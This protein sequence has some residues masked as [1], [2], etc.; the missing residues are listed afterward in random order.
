MPL[1][2]QIKLTLV[3]VVLFLVLQAVQFTAFFST[4]AENVEGQVLDQ[5]ETSSRIF[6]RIFNERADQ[7]AVSVELL[8]NDFGFKDAVAE[9]EEATLRSALENL[10]NRI[11][12]ELAGVFDP[13]GELITFIGPDGLNHA[14]AVQQF[15][16]DRLD[17]EEVS[18]SAVV[19][20][21]QVFELVAAPIDSP[22]TIGWIVMGTALNETAAREIKSLSSID[23]QIAFL[24]QDG[25]TETWKVAASSGE[26]Q[27]LADFLKDQQ[28]NEL[29]SPGRLMLGS[30]PFASW[31]VPIAS[32][33]ASTKLSALLY[34]SLDIAYKPYQELGFAVGAVGILSLLALVIGAYFVS[35]GIS[36][37]LAKLAEAAQSLA[38]GESDSLAQ[39]PPQEGSKE[40][41]ALTN[42]FRH[43][44]GAVRDRERRIMH[45][46]MHDTE[47]GLPNRLSFEQ[48]VTNGV[49]LGTPFFVFIVTV[50]NLSQLRATL[51]LEQTTRLL[52]NTARRLSGHADASLAAMSFGTFAFVLTG[53]QS[54]QDKAES[55]QADFSK[56]VS[57]DG[58]AVDINV[59]IGVSR[60]PDHG[61]DVQTLLRH[62]HA[63]TDM[64]RK[65]A[66]R[67]AYYDPENDLN[68][69][70]SLTLMSDLRYGIESGEV[71]FAYQPKLC[72]KTGKVTSVE[73]L[74]R[75]ISKARGFVAPDDFIPLAERTGEIRTLTRWGLD[76]VICQVAEWRDQGLELQV[77]IN[78][79]SS[80]LINLDLP[81]LIDEGFKTYNVGPDSLYL[82]VTESAVMADM[83]RALATLRELSEMGIHLAIDDYGTGYSSLSYLKSL[84]VD[85]LKIDKSFILKL[86]EEE[87][88]NIL[89]KSTIELGHTL[90]LKVTA[91]GVED[92]VSVNRLKAYGCDHI[93]GYHI[94]RPMPAE[95]IPAA[96]STIEAAGHI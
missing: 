33:V 37:P 46:A 23:L 79:S 71:R 47:T 44:V 36:K 18:V 28:S 24:F 96:I 58:V 72:L 91:E 11:N 49:R 67:C 2:F 95:D 70:A 16:V 85:E 55:I 41:A 53:D 56:P 15:V 30:E 64:A 29:G 48:L 3:F 13:D 87:Q 51:S 77:G 63:A 5:L 22:R 78:L 12:V 4:T 25:A 60:Y 9:R 81:T 76:A 6:T 92:E 90:G 19:I 84:P 8:S 54:G 80:D 39:L 57:V 74:V 94:A 42:G 32:A 50:E 34:Y 7:L 93:Q 38:Q 65:T 31:Q 66:D 40:I 1:R 86:A 88:D 10:G 45:Q 52:A 68:Q 35:D 43:M 89:V 14:S 62:G 83:D 73:A 21:G 69:T 17:E 82:E 20:G 59:S 26:G 61:E 27:A 75:W